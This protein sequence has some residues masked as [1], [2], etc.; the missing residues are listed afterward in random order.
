MLPLTPKCQ[1]R[2]VWFRKNKTCIFG[3]AGC[4]VAFFWKKFFGL[5]ENIFRQ[6]L[7]QFTLFIRILVHY[8]SCPIILV[9]QKC[10]GII[11]DPFV[12]LSINCRSNAFTD[13]GCTQRSRCHYF[14]M[15]RHY[16][17]LNCFWSWLHLYK[18]K[19]TSITNIWIE[20]N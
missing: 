15:D 7:S 19:F 4:T 3:K 9:G 6:P 8:K 11:D 17:V 5:F 1:A 2:R 16:F 12:S 10:L 20:K 18:S 14:G 13:D